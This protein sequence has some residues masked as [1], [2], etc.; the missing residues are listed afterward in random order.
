M[1]LNTETMSKA[2]VKPFQRSYL[3]AYNIWKISHVWKSNYKGTAGN[4]KPVQHERYGVD[5][6]I[7]INYDTLNFT[8]MVTVEVITL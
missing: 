8:V 6:E 2:K 3:K 5:L 4:M 7:K 1:V